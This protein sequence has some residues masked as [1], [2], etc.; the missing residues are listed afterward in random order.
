MDRYRLKNIMIIILAMLNLALLASL[1]YRKTAERTAWMRMQEQI[2]EL[3]AADGVELDGSSIPSSEPA[4]PLTMSRD[5]KRERAVAAFFLGDALQYEDQGGGIY[6]YTSHYGVALFRG[7]GSFDIVGSKPVENVEE[8]CK[9]FCKTFSYGEPVFVLDD[10]GNGVATATYLA[11]E[12]RVYNC[13]VTIEIEQGMIQMA[14]GTI[15]PE[16]GILSATERELLSA[17]AALTAFQK[18]R[19]E[20]GA[21]VSAVTEIYPC[22]RLQ[23]TTAVPMALVPTWCIVTDT[24]RYYVNCISGAVTTG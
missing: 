14:G 23:S 4:S 16:S 5:G 13:T 19:R 1:A 24:S 11:N 2:V 7:D 8:T 20:T 12:Q 3:F 6:S 21:V 9:A 15:L 22:Y 18:M 17:P 10:Q